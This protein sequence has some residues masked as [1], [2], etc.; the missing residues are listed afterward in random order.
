MF[1]IANKYL[2]LK[3]TKNNEKLLVF[4]YCESFSGLLVKLKVQHGGLVLKNLKY[5]SGLFPLIYFISIGY[6]IYP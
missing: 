5:T 3:K 2:C 4:F 1:D 6:A